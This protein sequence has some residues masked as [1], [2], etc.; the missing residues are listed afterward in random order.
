MESME[1]DMRYSA[2]HYETLPGEVAHLKDTIARPGA[3]PATTLQSKHYLCLSFVGARRDGKGDMCGDANENV[4][5]TQDDGCLARNRSIV[6]V[7]RA[8][9]HAVQSHGNRSHA[10]VHTQ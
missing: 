10:H 6:Y 3:H 9:F 2:V 4:A 1:Y 8:F 5:G 7:R